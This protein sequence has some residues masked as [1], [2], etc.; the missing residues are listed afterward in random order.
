MNNLQP[1]LCEGRGSPFGPRYSG[2]LNEAWRL[3]RGIKR[4][5]SGAVQAVTRRRRSTPT[6]LTFYSP[7]IRLTDVHCFRCVRPDMI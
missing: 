6:V 3:S 7:S 2:L 4:E 1:R 5:R